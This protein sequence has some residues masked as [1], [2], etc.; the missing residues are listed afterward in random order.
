MGFKTSNPSIANDANPS[1]VNYASS[2]ECCICDTHMGVFAVATAKSRYQCDTHLVC[3][4]CA[5]AWKG[6]CPLCRADNRI[7]R[8]VLEI[9]FPDPI[10]INHAIAA[11]GESL[12]GTLGSLITFPV[13]RQM[14]VFLSHLVVHQ[15][16]RF[17]LV[18][19]NGNTTSAKGPCVCKSSF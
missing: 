8:M 2:G 7:D 12:L 11:A 10:L 17:A 14:G 16:E 15:M 19:S 3:D 4:S 18:T 9:E 6:T 5:T 13:H 1:I